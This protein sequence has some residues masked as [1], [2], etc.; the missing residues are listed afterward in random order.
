MQDNF[1][2]KEILLEFLRCNKEYFK[3]AFH[4]NEIGIFGSYARGE[5]TSESDIDLII[6][7]DD[8]VEDI[9]EIKQE[10]RRIFKEKFDKETDIARKK[11]LKTRIKDTIF[12][13][14]IYA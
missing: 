14:V 7:F 10:L 6:E 8:N 1:I 2:D 12:T 3:N 13:D 5:Q 11:Y 4:I 9:Y